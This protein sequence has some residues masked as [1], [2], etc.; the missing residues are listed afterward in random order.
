MGDLTEEIKRLCRLYRE[1][2]VEGGCLAEAEIVRK[3]LEEFC[4]RNVRRVEEGDLALMLA[5]MDAYEVTRDEG[6]LQAVLD[7]ASERIGGL[8]ASAESVRLLVYCWYYVEE[9]ECL[10]KAW[11]MLEELRSKGDNV[12][13]LEEELGFL[14]AS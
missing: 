11:N 6:M 14:M 5:L 10:K 7:A 1:W 3:R 9:K 13:E 2:R 4:K 8:K 12:E